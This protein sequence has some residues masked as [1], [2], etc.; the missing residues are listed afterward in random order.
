MSEDRLVLSGMSERLFALERSLRRTRL[1]LGALVLVLAVL[2]AAGW[3][4][5]ETV[6]AER[7]LLVDDVGTPVIALRGVLG[8]PTPSLILETP[9]GLRVLTLGPAVRPVR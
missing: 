9:G 3:R 1:G 8:T 7:V 4:R 6:E 5:V 2:A